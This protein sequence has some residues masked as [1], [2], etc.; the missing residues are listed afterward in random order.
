MR[1]RVAGSAELARL[2]RLEQHERAA[3]RPSGRWIDRQR[4]HI[5]V[6]RDR[7]ADEG[8]VDA[9]HSCPDDR[10]FLAIAETQTPAG[11]FCIIEPLADR[12]RRRVDQRHNRAFAEARGDLELHLGA[13]CEGWEASPS[14]A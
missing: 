12:V 13:A 14:D 2:S 5:A 8:A 9:G 1:C 11:R 10:R 4:E 3:S 6:A 7:L